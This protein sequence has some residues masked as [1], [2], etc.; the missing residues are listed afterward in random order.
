MS[1]HLSN[2]NSK[3]VDSLE[4]SD[5]KLNSNTIETCNGKDDINLFLTFKASNHERLIKQIQNN[6]SLLTDTT[7]LTDRNTQIQ[8]LFEKDI[9]LSVVTYHTS[10]IEDL[11]GIFI[12]EQQ[13]RESL[14]KKLA[15]DQT[16]DRPIFFKRS[17]LFSKSSDDKNNKESPVQELSYFII[18]SLTSMLLT[19]IKSAENNDPTIVYQILTLSGQLCEQIPAKC[20]SIN[21]NRL[22]VSLKP[23]T[24]YIDNLTLS[25]DSMVAKQALK[26]R[27]SFSIAQGSFKNI[28]P[29][30][31]YLIF[32][33]DDVFDFRSLFIPLNDDLTVALDDYEKQKQQSIHP[34]ETDKDGEQEKD[35]ILLTGTDETPFGIYE[36]IV[37]GDSSPSTSGNGT[38]NYPS[39][40]SPSNAFDDDTSTKY[41]NFGNCGN[42]DAGLRTGLYF[43]LKRGPSI[44]T[45]LRFY[46]ANDCPDRDPLLVTL[47]GSN[48]PSE[49]LNLGSSWNLI[50]DGPSGLTTDPGRESRGV[51]QSFSNSTPYASYRLLIT[52]KR[53]SENSVQYSKFQLYGYRK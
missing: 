37:G 19:L 11:K 3:I 33:T 48:Q 17:T 13:L 49:L 15:D 21:D 35:S 45:G 4:T 26:V 9:F 20:L 46:T 43:T 18:Q 31:T 2:I 23:L 53:D 30:L 10:A 47:E 8:K 41:L 6:L 29:L 22:S 50:Y 25:K 40:E 42:D 12:N 14:T 44:V 34:T 24:N 38:G 36:T 16:T 1:Q 39:N 28:L 7:K 52:E 27:L 51:K 5:T 32:I